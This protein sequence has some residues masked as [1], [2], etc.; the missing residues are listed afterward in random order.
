MYPGWWPAATYDGR[1][2]VTPVIPPGPT[3]VLLDVDEG[4]TAR[5]A[6]LHERLLARLRA[7]GL[8]RRIADGQSSDRDPLLALRSMWLVR[9]AQRRL[10]ARYATRLAV[11][12][13]K[14][15]PN[16]CRADSPIRLE[17]AGTV[18]PEL[19]M[20]ADHLLA[21]VPVSAR[22]VALVRVLLFEPGSPLQN[23]GDLDDLRARTRAVAAA[24]EPHAHW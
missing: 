19:I 3:L 11:D 15:F 17:R 18:R 22:G 9:P 21:S 23:A 1:V 8:D 14:L 13:F 20:V 10:L 5:R 24:L 4:V 12:S 7:R 6:L 16:D 2:I